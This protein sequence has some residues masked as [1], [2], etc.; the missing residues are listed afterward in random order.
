[1]FKLNYLRLKLFLIVL[2]LFSLCL[3][4]LSQVT[5]QGRE[6]G[7][8]YFFAIQGEVY[9]QAAP[10]AQSVFVNGKQIP[11]D[12]NLNYKTNVYLENGQK[13]LTIQTRYRGVYF[14]KKYLVIR[15]PKAKKAFKLHVPRAEYQKIVSRPGPR[16]AEK[17]PEE[18]EVVKPEYDVDPDFT[19]EEFKNKDAIAALSNAIASDRYG[20]EPAADRDSVEW[21]NS[22]LRTPDFYDRWRKKHPDLELTPEIRYLVRATNTYRHKRFEGLTASQQSN[23]MLLN[24]L[25]LELTYPDLCPLL[26]NKPFAAWLGFEFVAELAPDK[27]LAVR[28]VNGKYFAF[29]YDA[30]TRF[31]IHLHEISHQELKDLLDQG[32]IPIYIDYQE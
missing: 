29:I 18:K 15:H 11:F 1:M 16:P 2:L 21:L 22:V 28:K 5:Y 19:A 31:W 27:F 6:F 23:I 7:P 30:K 10:G 14:T 8:E 26:R 13:Y 20:I 17:K 25:L 24:R 32:T 12:Q 3:P 4:A 9:G